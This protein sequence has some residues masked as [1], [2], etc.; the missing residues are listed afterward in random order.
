MALLKSIG[1]K[2]LYGI[3]VLLIVTFGAAMLSDLMPGSPAQAILGDAAT[4]E[5]VAELNARYGYDLPVWQ[6]YLDWLGGAIQGDLGVTLFSKQPVGE[7]VMRRLGVTA[8][9]AV[10]ALVISLAVSVPLAMLAALR[11]NGILDRVLGVVSS[12]LLSIPSFV[13]AVL[14]SLIFAVGL[15]ALPATGWTPITENLGENL[16]FAILPAA[17]LAIY[18]MAFFYRVVR[19]DIVGTL[20]EDFVLVARAKG[21]PKSYIALRH[22]LRPSL[23]SLVTV[24]GLSIGRLLGGAVIVESFFSVPGIGAEAIN[25]AS[26]KDL[27]VL[28]AIVALGVIL[29]VLIFILVDLAYAWIDPRVNSR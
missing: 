13:S 19:A 18:E 28:Q 20:R 17:A 6:R 14:L 16:K 2:L 22:V 29:Y 26:T 7:L 24:F 23:S 1:V 10:I 8:E 25:A 11:Q 5:Q 3:P 15:R 9:L 4:A 21:L 12:A 27:A